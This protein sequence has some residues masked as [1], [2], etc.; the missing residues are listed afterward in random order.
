MTQIVQMLVHPNTILLVKLIEKELK[1]S[2]SAT[3]AC[4]ETMYFMD[5]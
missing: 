2:F 3:D 5:K 1:C 4:H